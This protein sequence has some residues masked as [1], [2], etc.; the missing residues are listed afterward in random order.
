MGNG[1]IVENAVSVVLRRLRLHSVIPEADAAMLLDLPWSIRRPD[2]QATGR[3]VATTDRLTFL[4]E[5]TALWSRS[6]SN[7]QRQIT[8][9][10]LPGDSLDLDGLLLSSMIDRLE[11]ASGSSIAEIDA[12]ALRE[13][14]HACPA[15]A[16]GFRRVAA[17]DASIMREWLLSRSRRDA[18]QRIAHLLCELSIRLDRQRSPVVATEIAITQE[19]LSDV[20]GLTPVHVNRTLAVLAALGAIKTGRS[21]I[22]LLDSEKLRAVAEFDAGYMFLHPR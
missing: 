6:T 18:R 11:I 9:I 15:L 21:V 12:P 7:G 10:C 20:T 3:D 2:P 4:V 17:V 1:V 22:H 14:T 19:Q 5:G 13:L 16:I 8:A